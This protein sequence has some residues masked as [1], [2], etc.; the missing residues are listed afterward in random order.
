[1]RLLSLSLV[2]ALTSTAAA[3]QVTH[4][5]FTDT[6]KWTHS[7]SGTW[8]NGIS[9]LRSLFNKVDKLVSA[10]SFIYSRGV[11]T[12]DPGTYVAV[13]RFAKITSATGAAPI[14]LKALV[15]GNPLLTT[16]VPDQKVDSFIHTK[17]MY[18]T[19]TA[20]TQV[21]FTLSNLDTTIT[22]TNYL[23]DSFFV[24]KV[25]RGRVVHI[26]SLTRRWGH[27]WRAPHYCKEVA[28]NTATFGFVEYL[29]PRYSS[30]CGT[31][32][33]NL[34][35]FRWN[36]RPLSFLPGIHTGQM[37]IK[38]VN[39]TVGAHD[40]DFFIQTSTDNGQTWT[41]GPITVWKKDTHIVGQWVYSPAVSFNVTNPLHLYRFRLDS[42][43]SGVSFKADYYFDSFEVRR[44]Q[45]EPFGKSCM[46]GGFAAMSGNVPQ[47]NHK[48]D[49]E[50]NNLSPFM[51]NVSM[52]L[53]LSNP[54][55]DLSQI[56]WTGCFQYSSLDII[57]PMSVANQM[58]TLSM[59]VPNDT[60]LI[61]LPFFTQAYG[62]TGGK[63][64]TSNGVRGQIGN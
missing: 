63:I 9:E 12:L 41:S 40:L 59:T 2:L 51:P 37:R 25:E 24:G 53:G 47:L 46:N 29:N 48:F 32:S 56:G 17:A 31:G 6:A 50:V 20:K 14:D 30:N 55:F 5:S 58:A 61:G 44:G 3:Q 22:K 19:L 57:V 27:A 7:A 23:F 26:E 10:T 28:D 36:S 21:I 16:P 62:P 49:I 54:N 8:N 35:W 33:S 52:F 11:L 1:M 38:K 60:N 42:Y 39:S 43:K 13:A 18:F 34:W 15:S 4:E 45:F 64:Q